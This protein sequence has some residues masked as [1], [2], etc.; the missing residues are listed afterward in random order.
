[1]GGGNDN[2]GDGDAT[3]T[4]GAGTTALSFLWGSPDYY[5][6]FTVNDSLGGATTYG[7][8][9]SPSSTWLGI[10][11]N[12][13]Q[14]VANYITFSADSGYITSVVFSSPG[15]NAIEIANVAVVPEPE[16]YGLALAGLGVVGF[17]MRRRRKS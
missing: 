11:L 17:A 15:T 12:G 14:T 10:T 8:W 9:A 5:N 7:Q 6:S 2:N 16:A 13:D 4:L 3:L 1:M